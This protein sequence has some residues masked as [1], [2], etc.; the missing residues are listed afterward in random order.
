[1]IVLNKYRHIRRK[2]WVSRHFQPAPGRIF[3][4]D[5]ESELENDQF[6]EPESKK[7]EKQNQKK[8]TQFIF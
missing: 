2:F 4:V 5:F 3:H 7:Q 8:V 1:M 6:F